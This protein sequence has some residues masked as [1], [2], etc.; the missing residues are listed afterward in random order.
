M[1]GTTEVDLQNYINAHSKFRTSKQ[2]TTTCSP[3]FVKLIIETDGKAT[4]DGIV[5][6]DGGKKDKA[7]KKVVKKMPN[8]KPGKQK[9]EV[10]RVAYIIPFWFEE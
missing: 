4:F 8:W 7:A 10:Q 2:R 6:G 5:R 1:F 3:V 9:G